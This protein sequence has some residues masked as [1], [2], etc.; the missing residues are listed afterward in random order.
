MD[1]NVDMVPW[2][3]FIGAFSLHTKHTVQMHEEILL[4]HILDFD[5]LSMVTPREFNNFLKCFGPLE[6][7]MNNV[8]SLYSQKWFHDFLSVEECAKLLYNQKP[9]TF[10]VRFSRSSSDAFALEYVESNQNIRTVLI[11]N[12][13]PNGVIIMEEKGG[14]RVFATISALIKNYRDTLKFPLQSELAYKKYVCVYSE[15]LPSVGFMVT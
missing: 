15:Y 8:K 1:V 11:K 7:C 3:K 14:Q 10:L 9:G 2:D 4:K 6:R 12:D 5:N 13:M